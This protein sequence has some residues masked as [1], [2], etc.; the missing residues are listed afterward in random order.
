MTVDQ[1]LA[2][3]QRM[4]AVGCRFWVEGG[5]GRRART[6]TWTSTLTARL[7]P[8]FSRRSMIWVTRLKRAQRLFHS[9]YER[10][11]VDLHDLAVLDQL[12]AS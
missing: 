10:R 5:W 11:D 12:E 8:R 7:R 3:V 4:R 6:V 9:G 1:V 2:V